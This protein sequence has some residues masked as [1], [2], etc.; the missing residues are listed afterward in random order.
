MEQIYKI[1][2]VT[3]FT[4]VITP[5]FGQTCPPKGGDQSGTQSSGGTEQ[6]DPNDRTKGDGL[7]IP[8]YQPKDPNEIIGPQGYDDSLRWVS[9]SAPLGYTI[10][11]ENDPEFATAN[12]QKVEVRYTLDENA[13]IYSFGLGTFGFGSFVFSVEDAPA[14]YQ[15]RLDVRDS[16]G[17]YVDVVAGIDVTKREVFWLFSSI[18]PATNLP[19]LEVDKGFLPVNDKEKHNGEGFVSFV[20]KAK[21]SVTS[22]DSIKA[23]ASIVFDTN[24]AIPTN[25]WQNRLDAVAPTSTFKAETLKDHSGTYRFQ[26]EAKDDVKGSG[27]RNVIVY[28]S[29]N[30]EAYTE[31]AICTPDSLWDFETEKGAEYAFYTQAEDYTGN[32]EALKEKAEFTIQSNLAPTGLFLSDTTFQDDIE[33]GGFIGELTSKDTE[34]NQSFTYTLTE[35]DGAIHNDLFLV[36]GSHLLAGATFRCAKDTLYQIRIQTTDVGGL[37][38]S[39]SFTLKMT[40]VLTHPEPDTLNIDICEGERYDFFGTPY[41]QTGIYYHRKE[42]TYMCDSVYVLN[43]RV[44]PYPAK[45]I[46]TV[47]GAILTSSAL[48][49]NQWFNEDGAID[50]AVDQSFTPTVSG[51]YYVVVSNGGCESEPSDTY[52]VDLSGEQSISWNLREGWNWIS[53]NLIEMTDPKAFLRPVQGST[54]RLLSQTQE[55]TQDPTYGVVGELKALLPESSYKLKMSG[56]ESLQW[57]GEVLAADAVGITLRRGWNW[58]GYVPIVELS[59]DVAFMDAQPMRGDEIKSQVGFAS[60]DGSRWVGTLQMLQPGEGYMYYSVQEKTF[61]YSTAKATSLRNAKMSGNVESNPWGYDPYKYP[62]NMS[63]IA[64]VYD[65]QMEAEP[66]VYAIGAFAGNECRGVG[67]YVEGYLFITIHG[68]SKGETITFKALENV[69]GKELSVKETVRFGEAT[70]GSLTQPYTLHVTSSSTVGIETLDGMSLTVYPNPVRSLLNIGGDY[71]LVKEAIILDL[72]GRP[73]LRRM[74]DGANTLDVSSL[75]DGVYVLVLETEKGMVYH[76]IIKS[77]TANR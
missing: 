15:K 70:L 2:L 40:N 4:M 60:Y 71:H 63:M 49:G 10:Y 64:K 35:G 66:G 12:A 62:D 27:V 8:V 67:T 21:S 13:D 22:G 26:F 19:P 30:K 53:V 17:I 45:P 61:H 14:I 16:L 6:T 75:S 25:V 48:T 77:I 52:Y 56:N 50:G 51:N 1:F 23:Q 28:L 39:R 36:E 42:N 29:K 20:M 31:F 41:N 37:S 74:M 34:D 46:V 32:R 18:D 5:I 59:P 58:L 72:N 69:T 38:Y 76:K 57:G 7:D 65:D 47:A 44:N 43:L 9:T 73:L 55:L 24:E 33:A 3:L 11:F 54:E 68:G